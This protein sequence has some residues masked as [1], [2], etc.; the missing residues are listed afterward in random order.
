MIDL[1]RVTMQLSIIISIIIINTKA[2][3]HRN[4]CTEKAVQNFKYSGIFK[5]APN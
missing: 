4:N 5:T 1:W 2:L 3:S